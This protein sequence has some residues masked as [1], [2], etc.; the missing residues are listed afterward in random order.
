MPFISPPEKKG[1]DRTNVA[2]ASMFKEHFQRWGEAMKDVNMYGSLVLSGNFMYIDSFYGNLRQLY[3][4]L[5]PL[6]EL[7][8]KNCAGHQEK[9]VD[10]FKKIV[11]ENNKLKKLPNLFFDSRLNKR[12]QKIINNIVNFLE[13]IDESI[14]KCIQL[15][16]LGIHTSSLMTKAEME[17]QIADS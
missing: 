14:F 10:S 9:I 3:I 11:E 7:N 17:G 4:E 16:G 15:V 13:A 12:R 5:D 1:F 2:S 8:R 6:I